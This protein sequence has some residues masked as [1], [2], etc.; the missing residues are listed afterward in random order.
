VSVRTLALAT[1]TEMDLSDSPALATH[2]VV[3]R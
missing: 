3:I 2:T 1:A